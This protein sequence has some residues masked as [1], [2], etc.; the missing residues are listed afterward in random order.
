MIRLPLI[1]LLHPSPETPLIVRSSAIGEDSEFASA[2][3]QYESIA[4][5]QQQ[6]GIRTRYSAVP[7]FLQC[8]QRFALPSRPGRCRTKHGSSSA[9][10][11]PRRV[12]RR[13]I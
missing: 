10:T 12:F 4:K 9:S 5:Y 13:G 1:E 8:A 2:A 3:G 11:S 7:K 6:S